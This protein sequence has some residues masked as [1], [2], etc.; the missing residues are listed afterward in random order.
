[1]SFNLSMYYCTLRLAFDPTFGSFTIAFCICRTKFRKIYNKY[2][3]F[4]PL[5]HEEAVPSLY[6]VTYRVAIVRVC[7]ISDDGQNVY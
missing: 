5:H 2:F 4:N 3:R 7:F 1:M 6:F